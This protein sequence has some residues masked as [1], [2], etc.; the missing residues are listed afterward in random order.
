MHALLLFAATV[1]DL[2]LQPSSIQ[3]SDD[4][5]KD[6]IG[7]TTF[8]KP[9]KK[10]RSSG[11]MHSVEDLSTDSTWMYRKPSGTESNRGSR[12][13]R[14]VFANDEIIS[15]IQAHLD[16]PLSPSA[17]VVQKGLSKSM[18]I[19][20]PVSKLNE[21]KPVECNDIEEND[22]EDDEPQTCCERIQMYLDLT[23]LR[24]PIFILMC[25]S[26]TLMSVG[27]PYMLYYLPAHVISIGNF[28]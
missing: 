18:E 24:D 7:E 2:K 14:N 23:L 15:K 1:N 9:I 5:V 12:R 25:L 3:E 13:R 20:T 8:I 28:Y 26:V 16:K 22:L 10:V 17:N 11:L 6:I 27:C 21:A 19:P 4:E